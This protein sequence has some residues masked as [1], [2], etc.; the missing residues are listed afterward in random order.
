MWPSW[1]P[2]FDMPG[3]EGSSPF[4]MAWQQCGFENEAK[5][6]LRAALLRRHWLGDV[7]HQPGDGVL[8]VE[9]VTSVLDGE[10]SR[11]LA[12]HHHCAKVDVMHW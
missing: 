1:D 12:A 7:L 5:G 3:V 2:Q 8:E 11:L 4:A 9:V 6:A 10:G